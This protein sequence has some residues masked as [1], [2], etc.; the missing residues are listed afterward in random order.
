[1]RIRR[2]LAFTQLGCGQSDKALTTVRE[3]AAAQP[4]SFDAQS[5]H[6]LV[7]GLRG[8][9]AEAVTAYQKC[10]QLRPAE[11]NPRVKL[12]YHSFEL[13][14][15][16]GALAALENVLA[17][18]DA[19]RRASAHYLRSI[20]AERAGRVA[21]AREDFQRALDLEVQTARSLRAPSDVVNH[22]TSIARRATC[23]RPMQRMA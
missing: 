6:A 11:L 21:E 8:Q 14:D 2:T 13:G 18:G 15:P 22:I 23:R 4:N 7:A 3:T 12:A 16:T 19:V 10:L 9:V 5:A 17:H 20:I 1:M